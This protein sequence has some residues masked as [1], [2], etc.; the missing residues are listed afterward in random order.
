MKPTRLFLAALVALQPVL[1]S[2]CVAA[3]APLV[4]GGFVVKTRVDGKS[5]GKPEDADRRPALARSGELPAP[6]AGPQPQPQP[7]RIRPTAEKDL[8]P[9]S[10]IPST[11]A[12]PRLTGLTALPRPDEAPDAASGSFAAFFHF[13]LAAAQPKLGQPVRSALIEPATLTDRPTRANCSSLPPAVLI[14]LDPGEAAF[15]L[16]DPPASA[17][18][19]GEQLASLRGA[20]LTILWQASLPANTS[21]RLHTT[22]AAV[23]LDPNRTDR[24]LLIRKT[25]ESK[26]LRRQNAAQDWCI[27]AMAGDSKGD[28]E[29]AFN[30]L[31]NPD[32]TLATDLSANL[33]DGWFLT[34]QPVH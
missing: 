17:P 8:L 2:G 6:V 1:L 30:Y 21:E 31:R 33:G 27:L 25:S 3:V 4:A 9:E 23:G 5:D 10:R 32:G 14:D 20:G 12:S 18:G 7:Q 11:D 22:L 29:E 19:L 24:L 26:Q 15:D 13:A 34:P 28:F 16:D